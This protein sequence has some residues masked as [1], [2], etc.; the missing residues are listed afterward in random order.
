MRK[1]NESELCA[2]SG[3]NTIDAEVNYNDMCIE[4]PT[5]PSLEAMVKPTP[6]KPNKP[7]IKYDFRQT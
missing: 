7:I 6:G 3:G 5:E 4:V 1:L 2:V